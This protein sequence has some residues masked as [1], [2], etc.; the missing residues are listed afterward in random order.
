[1]S[2]QPAKRWFV[3]AIHDPETGDGTS[4]KMS[5]KDSARFSAAL[6]ITDYPKLGFSR[7][8]MLKSSPP[9]RRQIA[10]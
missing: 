9:L 7:K 6:A 4:D 2:V 3:A 10:A 1:M 8:M 5:F